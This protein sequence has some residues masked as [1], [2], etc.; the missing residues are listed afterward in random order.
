M[1]SKDWPKH[2]RPASVELCTWALLRAWLVMVPL[3]LVLLLGVMLRL[4]WGA[5]V[6]FGR[7]RSCRGLM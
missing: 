6:S 7:I 4:L 3:P 1:G 2:C 5:N